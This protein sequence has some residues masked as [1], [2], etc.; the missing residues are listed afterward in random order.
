M[1]E[2]CEALACKYHGKAFFDRLEQPR[3]GLLERV[4]KL[5]T[6]SQKCKHF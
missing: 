6:L 3:E 5:D 2:L 1:T 4:E